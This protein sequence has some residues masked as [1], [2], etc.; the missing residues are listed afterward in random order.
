MILVYIKLLK[1]IQV[2]AATEQASIG[3][4]SKENS[5]SYSNIQVNQEHPTVNIQSN[6]ILRAEVVDIYHLFKSDPFTIKDTSS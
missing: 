6:P 2:V 5:F 1:E 3:L 4:L